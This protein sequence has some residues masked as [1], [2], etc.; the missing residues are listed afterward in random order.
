MWE[1]GTYDVRLR[2]GETKKMEETGP[3]WNILI[4]QHEYDRN[5]NL[6][7][8]ELLKKLSIFTIHDGL[9]SPAI[10][11]A[12]PPPPPHLPYYRSRLGCKITLRSNLR[13][14]RGGDKMEFCYHNP[15]SPFPLSFYRVVKMSKPND[16]TA[17]FRV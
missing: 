4:N 13:E 14:A 16:S 12:P 7:K 6:V 17:F 11:T 2:R 3:I 10:F 1:M 15:P 8:K 5:E 9:K